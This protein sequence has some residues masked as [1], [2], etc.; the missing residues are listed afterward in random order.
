M[1]SSSR[2]KVLIIPGT[3]LL[4]GTLT[5]LTMNY[6]MT[7]RLC[8]F[9][10]QVASNVGVGNLFAPVSIRLTLSFISQRANNR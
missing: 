7:Q 10:D 1:A 9:P 5:V 6:L 3:I 4:F 8:C 2:Y